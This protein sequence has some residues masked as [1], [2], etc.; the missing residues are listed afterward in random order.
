MR[1]LGSR[2][3]KIDQ[4]W[5][6]ADV[7][8]RVPRWDPPENGGDDPNGP[9]RQMIARIVTVFPPTINSAKIA[10]CRQKPDDRLS[11]GKTYTFTR[12]CQGYCESPT[13][14][15]AAL[16]TS[17][18]NLNL[19]QGTA[20]LQ[21]VDDLL[22]AATTR[23][24]CIGP[25]VT[26]N[27]LLADTLIQYCV[28]LHD[29]LSTVS[30]QV[31]AAL[32]TPAEGFVHSIKPGDWV[33]VKDLRRKRWNQARW[34]GP[35]QVLLTT[36]TAVKTEGKGND[37]WAGADCAL[38]RTDTERA[39]PSLVS[40]TQDDGP[41]DYARRVNRMVPVSWRGNNRSSPENQWTGLSAPD[42]GE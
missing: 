9:Y 22:V 27:N 21:Y 4:G 18:D 16:K 42:C 29:A 26:D 2:Y 19:S 1:R 33:L 24:L 32:P 7:S 12:L 25:P 6:Q 35:H 11:E 3:H 30:K 17:L 34:T 41:L 40:R 39:Q 13:I 38:T 31:K 23:E 14:Y 8:M 5:P 37:E 15:N 10:A 28:S 20:L 36:Y